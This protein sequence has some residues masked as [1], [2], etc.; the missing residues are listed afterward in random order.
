[1][2]RNDTPRSIDRPV[3]GR[4]DNL[5]ITVLIAVGSYFLLVLILSTIRVAVPLTFWGVGEVDIAYNKIAYCN[6]KDDIYNIISKP[7]LRSINDTQWNYFDCYF[8]NSGLMIDFDP[9][10]R[11]L[12]MLIYCV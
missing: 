5:G 9:L 7:C 1:M 2:D 4:W 11:P 8:R 6:S 12:K 10:Y 3:L